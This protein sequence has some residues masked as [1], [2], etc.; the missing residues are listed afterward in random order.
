MSQFAKNEEKQCIKRLRERYGITQKQFSEITG[1]P[2][3]SVENWEGGQRTPPEYIYNLCEI[4]I[5]NHFE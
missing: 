1:I 5:K 4:A 2:K 3:R